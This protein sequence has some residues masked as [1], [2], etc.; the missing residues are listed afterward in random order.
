MILLRTYAYVSWPRPSK[1][2][3]YPTIPTSKALSLDLFCKPEL[4]P[5]HRNIPFCLIQIE[6]TPFCLSQLAR[7]K[8]EEWRQFQGAQCNESALVAV[9]GS[10]ECANPDRIGDRCIM[11]LLNGEKCAAQVWR[12]VAVRS[13]CG[14]GVAEDL[15]A[16]LL[17]TVGGIEG[18]SVFKMSQAGEEVGDSNGSDGFVQRRGGWIPLSRSERASVRL[19]QAV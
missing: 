16:V 2:I 5:F 6:F 1:T 8:K 19:W 18:A 9:N 13:A 4:E 3:F 14:Y 17:C 12:R 11:L 10:K 7:T 15:P